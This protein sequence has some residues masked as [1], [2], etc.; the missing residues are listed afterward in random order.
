LSVATSWV[1]ARFSPQNSIAAN[2]GMV[3]VASTTCKFE[4]V[5]I[6]CQ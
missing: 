3:V 4:E 5:Y 6:K 2:V 1:Y